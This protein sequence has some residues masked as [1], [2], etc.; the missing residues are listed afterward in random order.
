MRP[1]VRHGPRTEPCARLHRRRFPQQDLPSIY[2]SHRGERSNDRNRLPTASCRQCQSSA[3]GFGWGLSASCFACLLLRCGR[4]GATGISLALAFC[5]R[6][7]AVSAVV[8]GR[9]DGVSA[10]LVFAA[11]TTISASAGR[12]GSSSLSDFADSFKAKGVAVLLRSCAGWTTRADG[13]AATLAAIATPTPARQKTASHIVRVMLDP[14]GAC[15]RT[16]SRNRHG[17]GA[18]FQD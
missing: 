15:G 17:M 2:R 10:G 13:G 1:P 4:G 6:G 8:A 14:K 5:Q 9:I 11:G 7:L 12:L 18:N 3:L 16:P